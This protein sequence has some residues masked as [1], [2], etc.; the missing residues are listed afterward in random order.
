MPAFDQLVRQE[1]EAA[2]LPAIWA[3]M[4]WAPCARAFNLAG[5]KTGVV[6]LR[7]RS[8][9]ESTSPPLHVPRGPRVWTRSIQVAAFETSRFLSLR[10]L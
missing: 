6:I 5:G 1:E 9:E 8:A 4:T 2:E 7:S 10:G 3:G